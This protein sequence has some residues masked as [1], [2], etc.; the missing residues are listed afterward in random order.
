LFGHLLGARL[1]RRILRLD[2]E[3]ELH[4]RCRVFMAAIDA[5][6][7]GQRPQLEQRVPHHRVVAFEHPPAADREQRV[8]GE[9]G[10][11]A[12]EHVGDVVERVSGCLQHARCE[13]A[14]LHGVAL[15]HALVDVG[16]R[17]RL[18][19]RRDDAA[20]ILLLQLGDAANVV[21]VMVGHQDVGQLPAFLLQRLDDGGGLRRIDRRGGLRCRIMNEIAVIVV[22]AGK[23]ADFCSHFGHS[24]FKESAR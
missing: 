11:V 18:V 10:L 9:Q 7:V 4:I 19:V 13:R 24:I 1:Q 20:F 12:I 3:R 15:L 23:D 8:G 22:E 16:D 17:L 2:G 6:V 5:R 14:H 21:A